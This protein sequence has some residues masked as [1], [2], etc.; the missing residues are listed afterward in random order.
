MARK[1][2]IIIVTG[3]FMIVVGCFAIPT[4]IYATGSQD[5]TPRQDIMDQLDINE[6]SRQVCM[7]VGYLIRNY[8]WL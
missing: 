6:C 3:I 2:E 8:K 5:V 7:A 4:I 1:I